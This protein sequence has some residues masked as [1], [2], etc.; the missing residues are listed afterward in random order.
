MDVIR[1]LDPV[2]Y[3]Y[4]GLTGTIEGLKAI[5]LVAQDAVEAA[6]YLFTKHRTKLWPQ[7]SEDTE[8]FMIEPSAMHWVLINAVKELEQRLLKF[9][10]KINGDQNEKKHHT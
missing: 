1:K 8:I 10:T 7:D 2:E 9:E 3:E 5:S 4:N 6:P